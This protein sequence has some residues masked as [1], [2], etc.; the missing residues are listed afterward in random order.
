MK[1]PMN[2]RQYWDTVGTV[3]VRDIVARMGSSMPYAR[4]LKYGIKRPG[5]RFSL[6]FIEA[7]REVTPGFAPDLELM[8]RG[9][10]RAATRP[11]RLI[12]PSDEFLAAQRQVGS[13]DARAA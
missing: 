10:P 1:E 13:Q 7:A 3:N 2:L 4:L 5:T 8:L 11:G 12:A 9:V 6:A